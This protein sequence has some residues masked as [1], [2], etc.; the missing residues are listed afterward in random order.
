MSYSILNITMPQNNAEWGTV[1]INKFTNT[2]FR[3]ELIEG[4]PLLDTTYFANQ[5]ENPEEK[6]RN[7]SPDSELYKGIQAL[8]DEELKE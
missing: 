1:Q 5:L 6:H 8:L 2:H 3:F 4:K 7:L